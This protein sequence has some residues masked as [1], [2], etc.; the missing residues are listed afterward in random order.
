[1]KIVVTTPTG[2]VGSTLVPLLMDAGAE[3]RLIAR[4]FDKP[5]VRR[6]MAR[7][8]AIYVGSLDEPNL[9]ARAFSGADAVFWLT[10]PSYEAKDLVARYVE[11]G[12]TAAS[13]IR[14][15]R[16]PYVVHC[17]SFGA[18]LDTPPGPIRGVRRVEQMLDATGAS[19]THLR[20]AYFMDNDL[21][22]IGSIRAARS[23]FL[24]LPGPLSIPRIATRD[25][26][27]A[28]SRAL[29]EPHSGVRAIELEGPAHAS[30]DEDAAAI[31]R[32][33]GGPVAHVQVS[34]SDAREAMLRMGMTGDAVERV[35][36]LY[37]ALADKTLGGAPP[38]KPHRTSTT[39]D[40]FAREVFAPAFAAAR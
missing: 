27:Q 4:S 32:A 25:V 20:P 5:S 7:G 14:S 9:L 30:F 39:L 38:T 36:E 10:P 22:A 15:A 33:I 24:P 28:A 8:A 31:G 34:E 11:L 35:L 18:H 13:A 2:H 21:W 19:V 23:I 16:V 3:V 40:D 26:A 29:L 12:S 6:A 17:S 37:R 1:M